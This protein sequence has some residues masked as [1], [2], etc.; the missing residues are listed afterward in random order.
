MTGKQK[1]VLASRLAFDPFVWVSSGIQAGISQAGNEFPEYGQ[2][3]AGYGKRYGAA[4]LDA[5]NGGFASTA[6]CILLKQDP[7][8][9]RL[10][11]GSIKQRVIYSME[12]EFSAKSPWKD[13]ANRPAISL[14][15]QQA[16]EFRLAPFEVLT[17]D[18]TPRKGVHN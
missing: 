1:I 10:G 15:A 8:Y 14:E 2:G 11:E 4:T 12:Q 16:H 6:F 3:A 7:R 13:D 5:V 18:V 17:L 9:F